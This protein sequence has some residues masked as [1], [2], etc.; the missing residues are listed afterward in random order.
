[1]EKEQYNALSDQELLAFW[2]ENQTCGYARTFL[3]TH[4]DLGSPKDSV[5]TVKQYTEAAEKMGATAISITD[6]GTMYGVMPLYGECHDH[7]R[8]IKV[9]VGVEFYVCD[10]DVKDTKLK[11]TRLHLVCYAKDEIGYKALCRLVTESNKRIIQTGN[12]A[13]PCV[14]K[15]LLVKYIGEG[16]TAHGHVIGTSACIGGVV[17]GLTFANENDA[18]NAEKLEGQ[19]KEAER[20]LGSYDEAASVIMGLTEKKNE[21]SALSKKTF[22][23]R[24]GTVNRMEDG[25]EKEQALKELAE[26]KAASEKASS[27]LVKIN[28]RVRATKE[29]FTGLTTRMAALSKIQKSKEGFRD[30]F[31][32]W[33]DGEQ[34]KLKGL[35]ESLLDGDKLL[36]RFREELTWY[37]KL[38][39]HGDWYAEIQF[40]GIVA[41]KLY[42][43]QLAKTATEL[44][45]PLVAANDAH[46]LSREY[47]EARNVVGTLRFMGAGTVC[48]TAWKPVRPEDEEM[49]LKDDCE[50]FHAIRKVLPEEQAFKAMQS[51][52]EIEAKCVLEFK[53]ETHYPV[54]PISA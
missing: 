36:T 2:K 29:D 25:P 4:T 50:L 7:D 9:L 37:D 33:L 15:E 3:H 46:M 49:Y 39:G 11:H 10:D 32:A 20:L 31:S 23:K 53:D 40:H 24:E 38:F 51:R 26:E 47:A 52:E 28:N 21:L 6:H 5:L 13:Y 27:E 54:F 48:G 17:L 12:L 35:K 14:S 16:S 1:M 18:A 34:K 45:I 42:M 41:E 43:P 30:L 44:N 22:G 8:D 19:V